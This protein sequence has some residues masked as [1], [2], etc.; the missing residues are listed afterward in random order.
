VLRS[1]WGDAMFDEAQKNRA[2]ERLA[3]SFLQD[4]RTL[5][6]GGHA[7]WGQ[8]V[9]QPQGFQVGLYG[10]CS[11]IITVSAAYGHDRI[12]PKAVSYLSDLWQERS[13][14]GTSGAR[15]FALTARRA[16]FLLAIRYSGHPAFAQLMVDAERELKDR[17]LSDGLF[18]SWQVDHQRPTTG[19]EFSTALAILAYSLTAREQRYIPQHIRYAA[20]SLQKRMEGATPPNVGVKKLYLAAVTTTLEPKYISRHTRRLVQLSRPD[21]RNRDQDSSYFWDYWYPKSD[22]LVSRRDYFHVPSDA[23]DILLASGSVSRQLQKLA[24]IDLATEDVTTAINRGLYYYGRELAASNNQAWMVIALSRARL[25]SE[26]DTRFNR[27]FS[28]YMGGIPENAFGSLI[29]PVIF[30]F[31][32]AIASAVPNR[33]LE[34]LQWIGLISPETPGWWDKMAVALQAMG[35][36]ALTAWGESLAKRS[37]SYVRSRLP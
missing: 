22:R 15:N 25:L 13:N 8:F 19:D 3:D 36:I 6:T 33:L 17:M 9:S 28:R 37:V 21:E 14:T 34:L 31:I 29:L 18:V 16:F 2:V 35:L 7:G 20:E 4:I 30:L 27:F 32:A 5:S 1:G 11:G 23:V 26:A 12:P 24:A 10:T